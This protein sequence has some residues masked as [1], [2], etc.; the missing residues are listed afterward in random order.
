MSKISIYRGNVSEYNETYY[1]Q[2]DD[3]PAPQ[4]DEDDDFDDDE[5]SKP[6]ISL[7]GIERGLTNEGELI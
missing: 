5:E 4:E 1:G 6:K 3:T 7:T 2:E